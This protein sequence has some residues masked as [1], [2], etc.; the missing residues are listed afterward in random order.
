MRK[1]ASVRITI[2]K[3]RS[4]EEEKKKFLLKIEELDKMSES[5]ATALE[6]EVNALQN[7][8]KSLKNLALPETSVEQETTRT[9]TV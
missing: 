8:S 6:S 7:K 5:K 2:E 3:I 1:I 4:L 9:K